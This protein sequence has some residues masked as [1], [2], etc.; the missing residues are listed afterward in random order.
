MKDDQPIFLFD[1]WSILFH[2]NFL[3]SNARKW[4]SFI[5]TTPMPCLEAF[6]SSMNVLLKF[7]VARIGEVRASLSCWNVWFLYLTIQMNSYLIR[8][9]KVLQYDNIWWQNI[10]NILSSQ[11]I[12]KGP[13][14]YLESNNP[15]LLLS[16]V[17]LPWLLHLIQHGPS[18]KILAPQK[19]T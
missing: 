19:N 8:L 11:G 6:H 1:G 17:G 18:T 4:P 5:K 7:G 9:L 15:L 14:C 12:Y 10:D 2:F 3:L 16:F 13:W